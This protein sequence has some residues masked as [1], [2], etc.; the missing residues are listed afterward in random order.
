M[1]PIKKHFLLVP[2]Y[3]LYYTIR[4]TMYRVICLYAPYKNKNGVY[5]NLFRKI[6]DV[7]IHIG[8]EIRDAIK[9]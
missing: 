9:L 4:S 3:R 5:W 6:S 8:I 1:T 2:E 7:T